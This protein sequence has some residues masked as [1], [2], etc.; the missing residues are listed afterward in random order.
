MLRSSWFSLPVAVWLLAQGPAAA[1][2]TLMPM[3]IDPAASRVLIE[4]GKAGMFGFAGHAHEVLAPEI[5]GEVDMDA[6]N[7]SGSSVWVEFAAPALRVTGANE[8]SADV[9]E[10]QRVMLGERV[11]DTGRFRTI[12]FRSRRVSV[13]SRNG[14]A[15]DLLIEGDLTLHGQ[16]RPMTVRA[17]AA[18]DAGGRLTARGSFAFKQTDFGMEPVTAAGGA[19]RVKDELDVTFVLSARPSHDTQ[20]SR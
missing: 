13:A 9:A 6:A 8:P 12:A 1:R 10:V 16:T 4:V 14:S 19:V 11:L 20:L 18:L 2:G 3:T 5:R 17:S 7:L 15:A